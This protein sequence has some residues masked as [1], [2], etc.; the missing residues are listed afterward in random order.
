MFDYLFSTSN[1]SSFKSYLLSVF[2]WRVISKVSSFRA[3]FSSEHLC[4]FYP[5]VYIP[6]STDTDPHYTI[7]IFIPH[8]YTH[9]STGWPE[10]YRSCYHVIAEVKNLT[11]KKNAEESAY[12]IECT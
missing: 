10:Q 8:V 1:V 5:I 12:C 6:H 2:P 3:C 7:P 9:L 11:L 4:A